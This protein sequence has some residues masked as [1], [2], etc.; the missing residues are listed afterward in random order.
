M[1]HAW[2]AV[3]TL[4]RYNQSAARLTRAERTRGNIS[5]DLR[6]ID[7]NKRAQNSP[8]NISQHAATCHGKGTTRE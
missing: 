7:S 4:Y 1:H 8:R 5:G 6:R 2:S 3:P